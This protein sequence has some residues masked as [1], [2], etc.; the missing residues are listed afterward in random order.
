MNSTIF[1]WSK[2]ID[3]NDKFNHSRIGRQL[4]IFDFM[5]CKLNNATKKHKPDDDLDTSTESR[6]LSN[7]KRSRYTRMQMKQLFFCE[8]PWNEKTKE[9]FQKK[10][11]SLKA[12]VLKF[13]KEKKA[14]EELNIRKELE[15]DRKREKSK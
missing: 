15:L 11:L 12:E 10:E 9:E 2:N 3:G 4:K 7:T 1:C 6:S 8:T 13:E 5:H 14:D